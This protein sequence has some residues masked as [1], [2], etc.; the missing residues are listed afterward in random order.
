[1]QPALSELQQKILRYLG[2]RERAAETSVGVNSAWLQRS[3][4]AANVA[5][6]EEALEDLVLRGWIV[7]HPLP[8]GDPVYLRASK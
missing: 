4:T 1:M 2:E 6:V 7:K 3:D 8:D 5:E